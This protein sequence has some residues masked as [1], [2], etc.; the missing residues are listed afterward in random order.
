MDVL[1]KRLV[2]GLELATARLVVASLDVPS[3]LA[4]REAADV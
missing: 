4:A 2:E 1:V 3:I